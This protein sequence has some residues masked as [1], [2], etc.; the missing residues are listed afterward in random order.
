MFEPGGSAHGN[1]LSNC[2]TGF[3]QDSILLSPKWITKAQFMY[4][5][6][7]FL[8]F[9]VDLIN[10]KLPWKWLHYQV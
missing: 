8:D 3:E 4:P 1:T 2:K 6:Q 5:A 7:N 10:S 9:C